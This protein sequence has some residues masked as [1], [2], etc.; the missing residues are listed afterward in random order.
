[1]THGAVLMTGSS[2]K[3]TDNIQVVRLGDMVNCPIHGHG[4]N[5]IISGCSATVNDD[6]L[7]VARLGAT[8]QCGAVIIS[9]SPDTKIG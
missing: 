8:S 3:K 5:P 4:I 2:T 9:G 6:N 1:M 7:F